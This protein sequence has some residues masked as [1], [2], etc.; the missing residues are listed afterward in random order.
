MKIH[1]TQ[2]FIATE[3]ASLLSYISAVSISVFYENPVVFAGLIACGAAL[4]V[5]GEKVGNGRGFLGIVVDDPEPDWEELEKIIRE[6]M[7]K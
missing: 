7:K 6:R 2:F 1:R 3:I 5:L 4:A